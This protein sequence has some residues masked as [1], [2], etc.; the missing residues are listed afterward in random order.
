MFCD[1]VSF[2]LYILLNNFNLIITTRVKN[3]HCYLQDY[4]SF[5]NLMVL[6]LTFDFLMEFSGGGSIATIVTG[7]QFLS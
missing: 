3:Q 6:F 5:R 1:S 7:H 4:G 2:F